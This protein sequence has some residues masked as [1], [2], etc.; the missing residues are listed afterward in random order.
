MSSIDQRLRVVRQTGMYRASIWGTRLMPISWA[1]L[2]VCVQVSLWPV[3]VVAVLIPYALGIPFALH[4]YWEL[5]V[6]QGEV[7][8]Q[9]WADVFNPRFR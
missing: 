2:F 3:G 4:A 5:E 1:V 9:Y 6:P 8:L 7:T